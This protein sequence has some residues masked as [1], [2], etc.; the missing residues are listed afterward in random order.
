MKNK[1]QTRISIMGNDDT[2][3]IIR[4]N[5]TV[6]SIRGDIQVPKQQIIN[7]MEE[8]FNGGYEARNAVRGTQDD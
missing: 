1:I 6:F 2:Y 3:I 4:D 8:Y 5:S 7:Q